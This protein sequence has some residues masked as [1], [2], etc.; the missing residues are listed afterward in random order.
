M[1]WNKQLVYRSFLQ[2]Y[3]IHSSETLSIIISR[4]WFYSSVVDWMEAYLNTSS[5]MTVRD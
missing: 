5:Q 3:D 4:T 2:Y 1:K